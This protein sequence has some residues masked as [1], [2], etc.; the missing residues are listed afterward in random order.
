MGCN[1][2]V[3]YT[4]EERMER[5]WRHFETLDSLGFDRVE[6]C[7]SI[8]NA[9]YIGRCR[10]CGSLVYLGDLTHPDQRLHDAYLHVGWH[11]ELLK[12]SHIEVIP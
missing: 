8:F 6:L 10:S 7:G 12:H 9:E 1:D 4:H 11:Q 3:D 5:R 2:Y